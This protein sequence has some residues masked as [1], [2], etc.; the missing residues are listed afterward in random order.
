MPA[1]MQYFRDA[2]NYRPTSIYYYMLFIFFQIGD[3][4]ITLHGLNNGL[5]ELNPLMRDVVND[6]WMI[7]FV[8]LAVVV[9]YYFAFVHQRK[10]WNQ[11]VLQRLIGSMVLNAFGIAVFLRNLYLIMV[12]T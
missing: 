12:Y 4:G 3:I 1:V 9:M 5:S 7:M 2:A 6:I 10:E 8:K 11:F